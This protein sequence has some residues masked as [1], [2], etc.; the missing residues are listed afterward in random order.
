MYVLRH[1]YVLTPAPESATRVPAASHTT[2]AVAWLQVCFPATNTCRIVRS[3]TRRQP[4]RVT[5]VHAG[6]SLPALHALQSA[7][8]VLAWRRHHASPCCVIVRAYTFACS[9]TCDTRTCSPRSIALY[10]YPQLPTQHLLLRGCRCHFP[11]D[12]TFELCAP[13]WR[14]PT[15]PIEVRDSLPTPSHPPPP[16][17]LPSPPPFPLCALQS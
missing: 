1:V 11:S 3:P 17:N 4:I 6:P 2:V 10:E 15:D 16:P 7:L 9:D 8:K 14:Q 5:K 13:I 12:P